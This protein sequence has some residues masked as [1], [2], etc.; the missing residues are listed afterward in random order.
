MDSGPRLVTIYVVDEALTVLAAFRRVTK[1]LHSRLCCAA[2]RGRG[3]LDR[4]LS[5]IVYLSG[6]IDTYARLTF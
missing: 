2:K 6:W 1:D 5:N 4:H 3:A